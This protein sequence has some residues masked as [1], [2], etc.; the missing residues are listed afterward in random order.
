MNG[1]DQ[2]FRVDTFAYFENDWYTYAPYNALALQRMLDGLP[3]N[4][5]SGF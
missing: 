1:E 5:S 3:Q 2:K 4:K